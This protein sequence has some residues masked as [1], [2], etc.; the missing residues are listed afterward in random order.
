MKPVLVSALVGG[1][2]SIV[3]AYFTTLWKTREEHAKWRRDFVLRYAQATSS[4]RQD[5]AREISS[6]FVI[7]ET[8]D[9][10]RDKHFIPRDGRVTV[11]R[12]A[13]AVIRLQD[14]RVS[15]LAACFFASDSSVLI[16]DMGSTRPPTVNGVA[17]A[18][19]Q[20]LRDGDLIGIGNARITFHR[21]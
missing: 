12:G 6:G 19:S 16:E 13:G 18:T 7:V 21:L 11:G 1:I 2:V 8:A 20:E 9:G 3:T 15:K 14:P 17:V 5:L 4:E 10:K